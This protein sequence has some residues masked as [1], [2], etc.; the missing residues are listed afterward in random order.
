MAA[1]AVKY[2]VSVPSMNIYTS[3]EKEKEKETSFVLMAG[4]FE[5]S[6]ARSALERSPKEYK[7][8][9]RIDRRKTDTVFTIDMEFKLPETRYGRWSI[10]VTATCLDGQVIYYR[11]S[12]TSGKKQVVFP[13]VLDHKTFKQCTVECRYDEFILSFGEFPLDMPEIEKCHAFKIT[14]RSRYP[15]LQ[16]VLLSNQKRPNIFHDSEYYRNYCDWDDDEDS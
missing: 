7:H 16:R 8:T 3:K 12:F 13:S 5:N 1:V 15:I 2:P 11:E 10:S 6:K 14:C 4:H 9:L